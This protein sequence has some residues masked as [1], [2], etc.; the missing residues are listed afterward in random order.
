MCIAGVNDVLVFAKNEHSI[1]KCGFF[2]QAILQFNATCELQGMWV[3]FFDKK[4]VKM[5][6]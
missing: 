2:V 1:L 5:I 3:L 6:N 4:I